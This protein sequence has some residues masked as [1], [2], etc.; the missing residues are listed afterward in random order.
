M[1]IVGV[2]PGYDRLGVAIV[3]GNVVRYSVCLS[4]DRQLD[5][6]SRLQQL[7]QSFT[8]LLNQHRPEALAIEKIFLER[9]QKTAMMV[10]EVR[11]VI[12]YL[13]GQHGLPIF[14]YTP[15]QIKLT[16][17]G[18]GRADKRQVTGMVKR[19]VTINQPIK[20]DDE[21]DAIAIALTAL[22]HTPHLALSTTRPPVVAK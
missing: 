7:G 13:A 15:L 19:L 21:F 12:C 17:T 16:V 8:A 20:H 6:A 22:A 9:N 1:I 2:D 14:E 5:F 18:F 3:E 4:T 11:G 10:S